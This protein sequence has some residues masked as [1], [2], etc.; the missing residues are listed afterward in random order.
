[1]NQSAQAL[2]E[3]YKALLT[4]RGVPDADIDLLTLPR[5]SGVAK[6]IIEYSTA[7]QYD[8]ILRWAGAGSPDWRKPSSAA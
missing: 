3:K 1:M 7:M 5:K 2:L 6:D 8:A 4:S